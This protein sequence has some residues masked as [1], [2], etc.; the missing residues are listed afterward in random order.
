MAKTASL[1]IRLDPEIKAKADGI[2]SRF[3]ITVADAVNIFL[4][5]SIMAGGLPFDMT[6]PQ[7]N[8]D[9]L[10]FMHEAGNIIS[11]EDQTKL[12]SSF[13]EIADAI[14]AEPAYVDAMLAPMSGQKI[15]MGAKSKAGKLSPNDFNALELDTRCWKFNREEA[16]ERR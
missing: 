14:V 4:H 13:S 1:N 8:A 3:G 10:A 9:N 16:N 5:K 12:Y 2:F 11:G 6:L 7:K 15:I